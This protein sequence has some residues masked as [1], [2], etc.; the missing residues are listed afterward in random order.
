MKNNLLNDFKSLPYIKYEDYVKVKSFPLFNINN[1]TDQVFLKKIGN[2]IIIN[3]EEFIIETLSINDLITLI[4]DK[5][6]VSISIYTENSKDF[7]SNSAMFICDFSTQCYRILS[8]TENHIRKDIIENYTDEYLS[9]FSLI[10]Y[11]VFTDYGL[12]LDSKETD[13]FIKTSFKLS[14]D[15][16]LKY[17]ATELNIRSFEEYALTDISQ[18]YITEEIL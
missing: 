11:T 5:V 8:M 14:A 9:E 7:L 1:L 4:L 17:F 3:E 15:L 18:I 13:N 10:D 12:K 6:D 16:H 2:K